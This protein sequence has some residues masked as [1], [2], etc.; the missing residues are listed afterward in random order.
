MYPC[1]EVASKIIVGMQCEVHS[2]HYENVLC[3]CAC[4]CV[5][6]RVCMCDDCEDVV[7]IYKT[8]H[9]CRS[10]CL[11]C[12]LCTVHSLCEH[13]HLRKLIRYTLQ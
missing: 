5:C 4:V 6:V 12:A 10:P 2:V 9:E 1:Y 11:Q 7:Y 13:V 3:V 8:T